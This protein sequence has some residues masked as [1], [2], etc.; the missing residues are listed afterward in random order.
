MGDYTELMIK[1]HLRDDV[2]ADVR[3]T[4]RR[5]V[6]G[7][8]NQSRRRESDWVPPINPTTGRP[9]PLF[10]HEDWSVLV[11]GVSTDAT[12]RS[13][14]DDE[15][16]FIN[17]STC[18]TTLSMALFIEWLSPY[19]NAPVGHYIGYTWFVGDVAPTP[20]WNMVSSGAHTPYGD[21]GS[22]RIWGCDGT[23]TTAHSPTCVWAGQAAA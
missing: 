2:P 20:I 7:E 18:R 14:C 10:D 15:M 16:V 3:D 19:L 5:A 12:V 23:H 22:C 9:H 6:A 21:D 17:S 13:F 11:N 8:L 1:A 4:L